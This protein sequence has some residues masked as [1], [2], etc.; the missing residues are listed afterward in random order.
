MDQYGCRCTDL[1]GELSKRSVEI[2]P[3]RLNTNAIEIAD[4]TE[5]LFYNLCDGGVTLGIDKAEGKP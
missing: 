5:L 1:L 2:L 4:A 3:C